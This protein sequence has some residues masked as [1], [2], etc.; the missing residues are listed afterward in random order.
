M[1]HRLQRWR[2]IL[3]A[4]PPTTPNSVVDTWLGNSHFVITNTI[5]V[6][7]Q[8]IYVSKTQNCPRQCP[9]MGRWFQFCEQCQNQL[10]RE[11]CYVDNLRFSAP[12]KNCLFLSS[13][14]FCRNSIFQMGIFLK[15]IRLNSRCSTPIWEN[16]EWEMTVR[17]VHLGGDSCI[18]SKRLYYSGLS[19]FF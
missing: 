1:N 12:E 10:S 4:P 8:V 17:I 2:A 6:D 7:S 18:S 15:D 11:V 14:N 9:D 13:P 3:P 5:P 19:K 16:F